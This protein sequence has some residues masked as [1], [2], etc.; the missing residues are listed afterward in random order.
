MLQRNDFI[1]ERLTVQN[2]LDQFRRLKHSEFTKSKG[3]TNIDASLN[4]IKFDDIPPTTTKSKN[5][6]M[7]L[8][9][10]SIAFADVPQ[11]QAKT[12][13]SPKTN[14]C[15]QNQMQKSPDVKEKQMPKLD[16]HAWPEGTILIAGDSILGGLDEKRMSAK[17]RVKVRTF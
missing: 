13:S 3:D 10:D 1:D 5:A 2:Q 17:N 11:A 9:L 6:P 12:V 7:N 16:H 8:S 15:P 14:H 4:S